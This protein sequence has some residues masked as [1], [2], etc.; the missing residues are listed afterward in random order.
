MS[1]VYKTFEGGLFF[2]TFSV[3]GWADVFTCPEYQDILLESIQYCQANKGLELYEYR[4]LPSHVHM[5]ASRKEGLLSDVLRDLKSFTAGKMI[6]LITKNERES[7][8]EWLLNLFRDY[9]NKSPQKQFYQF[10]KHDNHPFS[11]ETT[12][13]IE[14]KATY[15]HNNPVESGFVDEPWKW[16]LSSANSSGPLEILEL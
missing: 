10:W 14:Q 6:D 11:L 12:Y 1:E 13:M 2:V 8:K 4:I 16:R 9:G 15:I 3:V 5:I 7:R